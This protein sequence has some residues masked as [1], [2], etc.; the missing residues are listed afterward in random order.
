M[1]IYSWIKI[2]EEIK[3]LYK[4][5]SIDYCSP[6]YD[7]VRTDWELYDMGITSKRNVK[8]PK[9]LL[10]YSIQHHCLNGIVVNAYLLVSRH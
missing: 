9:E 6:V 4:K 10:N 7:I 5:F 2:I 3:N 8:F 1:Y